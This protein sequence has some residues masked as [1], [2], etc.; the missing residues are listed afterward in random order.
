MPGSEICWNCGKEID[1]NEYKDGMYYGRF[2][3]SCFCEHDAQHKQ[4]VA[5]YLKLRNVIMFDRAM[6]L[7]EHSTI[8]S[9]TKYKKYASAVQRHSADNVEMYKSAHEMVAAVIL[10]AAGVDFEINFK[11]D[12]YYVDFLIPGLKVAV[13]IDGEMHK[14]RELKDSNRDVRIRQVLGSAWEIIR[15]PTKYIEEAPE[16]LPEAIKAMAQQ[17]REIRKKNGGFLPQNY[18]KREAARY[19]NAMVYDEV[20]VRT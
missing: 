7:M 2:C 19:K 9:M 12:K 5:E 10:L 15:I 13:E 16:K 20:Y 11:V 18:S 8:T 6:R 14:G 4:T 3:Y 1:P 17:K